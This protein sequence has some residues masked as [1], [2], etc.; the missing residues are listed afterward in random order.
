MSHFPVSVQGN[1]SKR[2]AGRE[3]CKRV[4][5]FSIFLT[6]IGFH[7]LSDVA[8]WHFSAGEVGFNSSQAKPGL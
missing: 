7:I 3:R 4:I 5:R 6:L 1:P 2:V 8:G